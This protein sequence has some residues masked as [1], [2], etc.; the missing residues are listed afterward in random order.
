[1][2]M[3]EEAAERA[4]VDGANANLF[5]NAAAM[6]GSVLLIQ[7]LLHHKANVNQIDSMGLTPLMVAALNGHTN[8]VMEL[9]A[10]GA[11]VNQKS[12]DDETALH[13][14]MKGGSLGV[15]NLLLEKGANI[16]AQTKSMKFTPL[17]FAARF[18]VDH[19]R[20]VL[21]MNENCNTEI[22]DRNGR[23]AKEMAEELRKLQDTPK[24]NMMVRNNNASTFFPISF[25]YFLVMM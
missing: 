6:K 12:N 10:K 14:A 23:T 11:N 2:K 22:L 19:L 4:L 25:L 1:M 9:L 8:V 7:I 13:L 20:K 15:V 16:N 24:G 17:H 21:E 18:N 3:D 5:L